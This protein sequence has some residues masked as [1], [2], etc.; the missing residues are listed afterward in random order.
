MVKLEFIDMLNEM[1]FGRLSSKSI[2]KF[3]KLAREIEYEDGI[4][5]TEL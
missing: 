3:R 5:A 4:A 1:R 2:V